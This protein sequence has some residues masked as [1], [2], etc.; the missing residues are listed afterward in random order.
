MENRACLPSK[1]TLN[2]Q[3]QPWYEETGRF[4][5]CNENKHK[6]KFLCLTDAM[7]DNAYAP[8]FAGIAMTAQ[9]K[10][11]TVLVTSCS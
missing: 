1:S 2:A 9:V 10:L 4:V 5:T 11:E 3:K 8:C 6:T 7:I